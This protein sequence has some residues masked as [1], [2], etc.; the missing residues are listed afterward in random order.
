M[1][2]EPLIKINDLVIHF[3]TFDG[4]V[5]AI[6][7]I[8]LEIYE[9]EALGLVGETGCGKSVT[10]KAIMKILAP[11]AL[12]KNGTI[13]YQGNNILEFS[14]DEM[15]KI[16]GGEFS[17]IFQHPLRALNPTMK[18]KDQIF[19][20]LLLHEKDL[21][22]NKAIQ[23]VDDK[24]PEKSSVLLNMYKSLLETEL[25]N[26]DALKLKI[27]SRIPIIKGYKKYLKDDETIIDM[28]KRTDIANPSTVI[29]QYPHELSGGMRQ[30]VMIAM[31][32]SGEPKMIIAD[33]PTTAVDVTI[34]AKV[35]RLIQNL[36]A[37]Y[38][39]SLLLI[40]HNL[41]I[42]AEICD[43]VAVMYAGT[44]VE[45]CDVYTL[46]ENPVHP[47]T[48]GLINAVPVI[49]EKKM[50]TDI[51]GSVPDFLDPPTGCRFH[52]RCASATA[53]CSEKKPELVEIEKGH[54]VACHTFKVDV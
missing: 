17:M 12:L 6:D 35:L 26:P 42:V 48:I 37:K 2:M 53:A 45:V 3:S 29:E 1:I 20:S 54:L 15:S 11:N 36:M 5:K 47:Y 4:I 13:M 9:G 22:L 52:P 34:Q 8:N 7:G 51:K 25:E 24:N 44:I 31:A 49:G 40:T 14:E 32:L 23:K 30:R 39:T 19:E 21:L 10:S 27:L 33:E 28:L 38:N 46:F 41:G 43:R 18:I 50:L 16:R